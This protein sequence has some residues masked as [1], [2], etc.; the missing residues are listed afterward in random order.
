MLERKVG[1]RRVLQC[2]GSFESATCVQCELNVPGEEIEQE[3][4]K[5]EVPLCPACN[6]RKSK[7]KKN[8]KNKRKKKWNSD[9]EDE[10]ED[11]RA[12]PPGIMKVP[13]LFTVY[14]TSAADLSNL[15][16]Y[17]SPTSRFSARSSPQNSTT[18]CS[19]TEMKLI[20]Y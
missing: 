9:D 19:L 17:R 20:C 18:R 1:V 3:I 13:P 6:P 14:L 10:S 15:N 11:E 7:P 5:G 8:K 4:M 12:Y 16:T 2:H